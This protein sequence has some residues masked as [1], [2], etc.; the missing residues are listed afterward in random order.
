MT[1]E[2]EHEHE[3]EHDFNHIPSE[4]T[5][6]ISAEAVERARKNQKFDGCL[7][8]FDDKGMPDTERTVRIS[9][10]KPKPLAGFSHSVYAFVRYQMFDTRAAKVPVDLWGY[11]YIAILDNGHFSVSTVFVG[12][13]LKNDEYKSLG[14]TGD[15]VN[16]E[17]KMMMTKVLAI[18]PTSQLNMLYAKIAERSGDTVK[19]NCFKAQK[20][21]FA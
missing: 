8:A 13:L 19:F 16:L 7:F 15:E 9:L 4:F 11:S 1:K 17:D 10:T 14:I 18:Y 21:L 6:R 20:N 12:F 5:E 2:H 3:H